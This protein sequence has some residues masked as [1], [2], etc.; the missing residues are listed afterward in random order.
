MRLSSYDYQFRVSR[1]SYGSTYNSGNHKS[2]IYNIITKNKNKGTQGLK[3]FKRKPPY[4]KRKSKKDKKWLLC[5]SS[6]TW[7][8]YDIPYVVLKVDFYCIFLYAIF[9]A[10][11]S[12]PN[13]GPCHTHQGMLKF[14][15]QLQGDSKNWQIL[16]K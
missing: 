15:A 6:Q 7:F 14:F 2:K 9:S 4:H 13:I 10:K 8:F 12:N 16:R 3:E 5:F 11:C 1:F